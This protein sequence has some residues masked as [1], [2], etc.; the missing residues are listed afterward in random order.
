[1]ARSGMLRV[2]LKCKRRD[3]KKIRILEW[4]VVAKFCAD[5]RWEARCS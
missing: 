2:I 3:V 1:M 5:G 4:D